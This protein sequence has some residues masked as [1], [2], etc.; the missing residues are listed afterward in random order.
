[1][2]ASEGPLRK[3]EL[4]KA[5]SKHHYLAHTFNAS[6]WVYVATVNGQLAGFLAVLNFPH[7]KVK[8]AIRLHRT[9]VL[10]AFQGIGLGNVLTS[11]VVKMYHRNGTKIFTTT[12]HPARI[13]QL[14][15]SPDWTC[16]HKG[17]VSPAGKNGTMK[18]HSE[19]RIT[20]SWRYAPK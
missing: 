16:T 8:N 4:W 9:V 1:M 18:R 7:P 12:T 2:Y 14:S 10:P 6:A 11:H 17:R 5:F 13:K 19:S 20:T 3:R 15:K